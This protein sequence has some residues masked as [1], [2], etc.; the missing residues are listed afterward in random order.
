MYSIFALSTQLIRREK[1]RRKANQL[2]WKEQSVEDPITQKIIKQIFSFTDVQE[3]P[4]FGILSVITFMKV[5]FSLRIVKSVSSLAIFFFLTFADTI[6]QRILEKVILMNRQASAI[7][8][9]G[10]STYDQL[11]TRD[12]KPDELATEAEISLEGDKE[13]P[14]KV[15]APVQP[16]SVKGNNAISS[17]QL[18]GTLIWIIGFSLFMILVPEGGNIAL[19]FK[20]ACYLVAC[21][22]EIYVLKFWVLDYNFVTGLQNL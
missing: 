7:G 18:F 4:R 22:L 1:S 21:G 16:V 19:P 2:D 13:T 20:L 10:P 15:E 11:D 17:T 12:D 9:K 14:A 6:V 8:S 5:W 3:D